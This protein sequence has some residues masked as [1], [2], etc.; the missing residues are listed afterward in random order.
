MP[1]AFV[2]GSE[3]SLV[4]AGHV[5]VDAAANDL[6]VRLRHIPALFPQPGGFEGFGAAGMELD[7]N[8][9]AAAKSVEVSGLPVDLHSTGSPAP[10]VGCDEKDLVPQIPRFLDVEVIA[11]L[12][13]REPVGK[14]PSNSVAA[15]ECS[16]LKK[17]VG[18]HDEL[19]VLRVV[20]HRTREVPLVRRCELVAH[21]LDVLL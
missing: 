3:R 19:H 15:L 6:D 20:A 17:S 13:R 1:M 4:I 5:R 10:M 16:G 18:V 8:D 12:K 11:R 21:D 2:V 7:A 14:P 9:L